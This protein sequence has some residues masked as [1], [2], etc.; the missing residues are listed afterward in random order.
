MIFSRKMSTHRLR[1]LLLEKI[2]QVFPN[3]YLEGVRW[4]IFSPPSLLQ[5]E[6]LL[7]IAEQYGCSIETNIRSSEEYYF[8]QRI[9]KS[10]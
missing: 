3:G 1:P 8:L 4:I 2:K 6:Q 9:L 10:R 7:Q 5:C